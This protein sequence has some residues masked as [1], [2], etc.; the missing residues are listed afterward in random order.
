MKQVICNQKWESFFWPPWIPL[1]LREQ[2]RGFWGPSMRRGPA[3]WIENAVANHAPK[4]GTRVRM[5]ASGSDDALVAGRF[6]F[7]WNNMARVVFDDG[8]YRVT[9]L[10]SD[11][12]VSRDGV[13]QKP[14]PEDYASV[15]DVLPFYGASGQ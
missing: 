9:Y 15:D 6:V 4:L 10:T 11:L 5:H 14:L 2:I 3:D 12:C 1:V 13:W 8:S 7:A